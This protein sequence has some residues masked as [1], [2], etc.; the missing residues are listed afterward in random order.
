MAI[1]AN[2]HVSNYPQRLSGHSFPEP[3]RHSYESR[4]SYHSNSSSSVA[5]LDVLD[6]G[7]FSS[8]VN[9]AELYHRGMTVGV[10][11]VHSY[12]CYSWSKNVVPRQRSQFLSSAPMPLC[13]LKNC[14]AVAQLPPI[15]ASEWLCGWSSSLA[16][17][18]H[19]RLMGV[20]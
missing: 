13:A 2:V 17:S 7:G 1:N 16:L 5:S 20:W 14:H 11:L 8:N 10:C 12:S 15:W 3:S 6:E 9:V 4:Q 19:W 18:D